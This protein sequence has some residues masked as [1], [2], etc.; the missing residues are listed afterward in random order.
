MF[1]PLAAAEPVAVRGPFAALTIDAA[2][3]R[4][5]AAG[6]T[7]VAV[8]DAD[9]GKLL[10]TIRL[11]AAR[12]MALE[13]LGGHVFVGTAGGRVSEIDPDRKSIVRSLDAGGPVERLYYDSTS[14]RL[15]ADGAGQVALAVFDAPAFTPKPPLA[16]PGRVPAAFIPDPITGEFYVAVTG[17]PEIA[18][19]DPRSGAV[20]T[21]FPVPGLSGKLVLRF[22][23]AFGQ[24]VVADAG[25]NLDVYDRAGTRLARVA[26]PDGIDA[27]EIDMGN[28]ILACTGA[29]G[30]TFVQLVRDA[31]PQI[32]GTTASSG[33]ELAALDAKTNDA[34]VV[35]SQIDGSGAVFERWSAAPPA[36]SPHPTAR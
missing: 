22:D 29:A 9:S 32:I 21:A 19:V 27:C 20:R 17:R 35:R 15:Y 24:L 36:P 11:G 13:P 2:R 18:V 8:L 16:L 25:G 12:S 10:A 4:I 33:P 23:A 26:V 3:R 5:F 31:A 14:G 34:V 1:A 6:A 7:S 28:H 30:L